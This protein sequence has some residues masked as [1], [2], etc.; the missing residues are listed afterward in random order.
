MRD[1]WQCVKVV[2][3]GEVSIP[4]LVEAEVVEHDCA[5]WR[6]IKDFL[7]VDH[8]MIIQFGGY[9]PQDD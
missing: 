4:V 6:S 1:K 3:V 9:T 7:R 8:L 2:L 5:H